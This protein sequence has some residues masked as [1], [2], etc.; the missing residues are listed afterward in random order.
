M[1]RQHIW[2]LASRHRLTSHAKHEHALAIC[3]DIVHKVL[4]VVCKSDGVVW[5]WKS[6]HV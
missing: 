2:C 1:I 6:G 4:L 5:P 3:L